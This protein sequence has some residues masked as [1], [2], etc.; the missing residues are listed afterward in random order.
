MDEKQ[1]IS[2]LKKIHINQEDVKKKSKE[3]YRSYY[4]LNK[5]K[6]KKRYLQNKNEIL[7]KMKSNRQQHKVK[8]RGVFTIRHLINESISFS[9]MIEVVRSEELNHA[10]STLT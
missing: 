3:Y 7:D 8:N 4:K 1:I 6:Y 10:S 5:E 9:P 2:D